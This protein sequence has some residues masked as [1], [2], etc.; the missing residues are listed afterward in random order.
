[1]KSRVQ[2]P[3]NPKISEIEIGI[4]K[5]TKKFR[6]IPSAES[7]KSQNSGDWDK[8]FRDIPKSRSDGAQELKYPRGS[9]EAFL[10]EIRL[11]CI[12]IF[13]FLNFNPRD[14]EYLFISGF[15][16]PRLFTFGISRGSLIPGIGIFFVG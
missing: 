16:S 3:K 14:P 2:N 7:Q 9:N 5:F 12:I 11:D 15:S 1:M 8:F 4:R 10:L 6:K 13:V